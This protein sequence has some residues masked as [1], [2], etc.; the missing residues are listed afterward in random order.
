MADAGIAIELV[1][2]NPPHRDI[3]FDTRV[4]LDPLDT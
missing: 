2:S 1:F 4:F 3:D